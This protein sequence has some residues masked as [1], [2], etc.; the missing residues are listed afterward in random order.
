MIYN[1][2]VAMERIQRFNLPVIIKIQIY[3]LC[4]QNMYM[5][6]QL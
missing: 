3:K 5:Y 2:D 1:S 6:L 4:S